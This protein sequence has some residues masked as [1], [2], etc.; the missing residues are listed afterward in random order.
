MRSFF[1]ISFVIYLAFLIEPYLTDTLSLTEY[2]VKIFRLISLGIFALAVLGKS[3][4]EIQTVGGV[5]KIEKFNMY[6]FYFLYLIGVF[7]G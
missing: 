4:W 1:M 7:C 2:S 3:G 5:T 6:W